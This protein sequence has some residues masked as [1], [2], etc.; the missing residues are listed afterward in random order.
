MS[1][2]HSLSSHLHVQ[3][4]GGVCS[5]QESRN[6]SSPLAFLTRDTRLCLASTVALGTPVLGCLSSFY[7]LFFLVAGGLRV[8][9]LKIH[10]IEV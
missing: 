3:A 5:I 1:G 7:L 8:N 9:I 10:F 2:L 4:P 6:Q